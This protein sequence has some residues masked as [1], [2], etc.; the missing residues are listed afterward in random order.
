[1]AEVKLLVLPN[2]MQKYFLNDLLHNDNGPAETWP[3]GTQFWYKNGILH[4]DDGK[5]AI[6][7]A[8][9]NQYW[10]VDGKLFR[11]KNENNEDL[12]HT[13]NYMQKFMTHTDTLTLNN[14]KRDMSIDDYNKYK[15]AYSTS[16]IK[17]AR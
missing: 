11:P 16:R 12:P 3:D 1:M 5:P 15:Y 14:I 2:G 8:N 13:L 17:P 10:Y 7:F 9:G 6:I 4:R